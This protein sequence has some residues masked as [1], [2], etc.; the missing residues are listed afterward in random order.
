MRGEVDCAGGARIV[1]G[2]RIEAGGSGKCCGIVTLI[3]GVGT[4]G[5]GDCR[6]IAVF[7]CV[8]TW[9]CIGVGGTMGFSGKFED[10]ASELVAEYGRV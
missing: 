4:S 2:F 10:L 5:V 8:R 6:G 1:E 9:F 3:S 7:F